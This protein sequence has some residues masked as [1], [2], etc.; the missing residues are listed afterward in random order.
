[1]LLGEF[2]TRYQ[3]TIDRQWFQT[4]ANFIASR[5]MS[6]TFWSWNPNSGDTGGI[7]QDDW[8]TINSEKQAVLQPLL[9]PLIGTG[10]APGPQIPATPTGLIASGGNQQ[11]NLS[12]TGSAGATS[13]NVYRSS[14]SNG[15]ASTPLRTGITSTTFVD[16]GLTNG[17][18]LYYRVTAVNSAGESARSNEASA[19]P[20]AASPPPPPGGVSATPG[21]RQSNIR[22]SASTGATSY[23]LYRGLSSGG[24][25]P[26]PYRAGLT[27]TSFTD[28]GLTNGTTYFYRLAAVNAAG[29]SVRS[30][31]VSA[32]PSAATSGNIS[33]SGRVASGTS[34]WF[35]ELNVLMTNTAPVTALTVEITVQKTPGVSYSGQYNSYWGNMLSMSNRQTRQHDCLHLHP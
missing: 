24:Q 12:W 4:T 29:E 7:L 21:D 19:I 20:S 5:G 2:G 28:T 33:V 18:A 3:T 22:W 9:A 6:F 23:N 17:A 25:G 35:G 16:S 15:Q 32:R 27:T 13:Y 8:R 30:N 11:V 34:P 26:T 31:E 1:M 14:T 10:P